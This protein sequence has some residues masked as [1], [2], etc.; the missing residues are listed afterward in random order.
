MCTKAQ[1]QSLK[2]NSWVEG[3]VIDCWSYL[4]NYGERLRGPNSPFRCFLTVETTVL[5]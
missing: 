5:S 2:F 3:T 4:R 1:F